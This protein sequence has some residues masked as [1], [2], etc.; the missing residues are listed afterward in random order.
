MDGATLSSEMALT[1]GLPEL[2]PWRPLLPKPSANRN[3]SKLLDGMHWL[4]LS[5]YWCRCHYQA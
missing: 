4:V 5:T 2:R 1:S 3:F